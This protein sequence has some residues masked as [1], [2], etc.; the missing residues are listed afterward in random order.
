L[1]LFV[2]SGAKTFTPLR[3]VKGMTCPCGL[4]GQRPQNTRKKA[5][6]DLLHLQR[7]KAPLKPFGMGDIKKAFSV[8]YNR[9]ERTT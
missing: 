7:G 5:Q 1:P 9:Q 4:Q 8:G 6:D 2:K 3:G